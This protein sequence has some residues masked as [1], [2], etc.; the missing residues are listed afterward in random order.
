MYQKGLDGVSLPEELALPSASPMGLFPVGVQ[1]EQGAARSW[2]GS[3]SPIPMQSR[4][5][6]APGV[7][8]L[9]RF[10]IKMWQ[11][12]YIQEDK[13]Y[14]KSILFVLTSV[15][16]ENSWD[17]AVAFQGTRVGWAEWRFYPRSWALKQLKKQHCLPSAPFSP[18]PSCW[19]HT[20]PHHLALLNITQTHGRGFFFLLCE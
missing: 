15:Q 18:S 4:A 12:P 10:N 19:P 11:S 14:A 6:H 20:P 16:R 9:V 3:T 7:C 13:W 17:K 2:E 5:P 8:S 1:W